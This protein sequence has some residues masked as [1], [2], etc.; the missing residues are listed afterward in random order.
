MPAATPESTR[1]SIWQA[2]QQGQDAA[3]IAQTLDLPVRTV[4]H[5]LQQFRLAG[6]ACPPRFEHSGPVRDP[7][8]DALRLQ[9]L[10]LRQQHRLWGAERILAQ[11]FPTGPIP[12]CPD[13]STVR[14]WL[15]QAGLAPAPRPRPPLSTPAPRALAVHEIW[16]MDACDY[17]PLRD[18]RHRV[19]WLRL[20]DEASGAALF[21]RVY[22]Q[23]RWAAVGGAAVQAA[24]RQAFDCWGRPLGLRVDNGNPWVCPDS[25]L[26][27]DLELWLAGLGVV[28][29]K[30]R[31]HVPQDNPRAER[32]QR[33]GQCWAEPWQHDSAEQ[34]QRRFDEEDRIHREVYLFDGKQT[35]LQA[36]PELHLGG[37]AYAAGPYWEAVCWDYQQALQR[38]GQLELTRKVD[39]S[40]CVSLYDH[41]VAVGMPLCGQEVAVHFDTASQ[42]WVV[43]Q[44]GV[45]LRRCLAANL[46]AENICTLRVGRRPGRSAEQTRRRRA[47]RAEAVPGRAEAAVLVPASAG[48][49]GEG[50]S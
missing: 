42:E 1:L 23:P 16:P 32:G 5:L 3:A 43:C 17:K 8:F 41:R 24:L 19:C 37:R 36:Y 21:T 35:R 45:Q 18:P 40:G 9:V 29:H 25:D 4:R 34:L 33:T 10:K 30:G 31:P 26:P 13:A 38:L 15:K 14:R 28:L 22:D 6:Q 20:L 48:R 47:A 12:G 49:G 46:S 27:T 39:K 50:R 11:L 7:A 44:A 2:A